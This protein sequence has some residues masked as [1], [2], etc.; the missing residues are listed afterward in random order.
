MPQNMLLCWTKI[1]LKKLYGFCWEILGV[2]KFYL[3]VTNLV[4]NS[5]LYYK[6]KPWL[7][8]R[9]LYLKE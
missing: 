7:F 9:D 3:T 6:G 1:H 5:E 8:D 4:I 2:Q